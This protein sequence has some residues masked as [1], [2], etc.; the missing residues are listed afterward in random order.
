VVEITPT[1]LTGLLCGR[2]NSHKSDWLGETLYKLHTIPRVT[3][4]LN[5]ANGVNITKSV[6]VTIIKTTTKN[7]KN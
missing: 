2:N 1:S 6:K 5:I 7:K 3:K 4:V